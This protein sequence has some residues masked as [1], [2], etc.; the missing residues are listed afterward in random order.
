MP[1]GNR[2]RTNLRLGQKAHDIHWQ[3]FAHGVCNTSGIRG[4]MSRNA[5]GVT[6]GGAT[7]RALA[8]SEAAEVIPATAV[9]TQAPTPAATS[10]VKS[11]A[12]SGANSR[13]ERVMYVKHELRRAK[14]LQFSLR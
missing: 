3:R 5:Q 9:S 2:D 1:R 6:G 12:P 13:A 14:L 4:C 10:N 11:K 7:P 8:P